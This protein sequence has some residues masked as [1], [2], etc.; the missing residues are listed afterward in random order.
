[1]SHDIVDNSRL[2]TGL[3]PQRLV[4]A[5]WV[6]NQLADASAVAACSPPTWEAIPEDSSDY[7][8]FAATGAAALAACL[9]LLTPSLARIAAT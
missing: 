8:A 4:V 6:E 3:G 2:W 7:Y 9:R 1:M 5:S